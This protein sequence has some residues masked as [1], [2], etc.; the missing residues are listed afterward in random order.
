MGLHRYFADA[1]LAADLL[2]HH[3]RSYQHHDLAL[4]A[5]ERAIAVSQRLCLHL[6]AQSD[7]ATG[8]RAFYGTQQSILAQWLGQEFDGARFHGPYS[9]RDIAMASDKDDRHVASIGGDSFLQLK[10]IE[11]RETHIEQETTGHLGC[12]AGKELPRRGEH[13]RLV[14][15]IAHQRRQGL[16]HGK[17]VIHDEHYWCH[18]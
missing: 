8:E 1:E 9:H 18:V 14:A 4:A 16:P 11:V 7:L 6:M 5:A 3:A 10:S 12:W 17:V 15:G 2:I 13:F